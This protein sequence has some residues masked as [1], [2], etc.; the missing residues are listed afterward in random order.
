LS[1]VRLRGEDI[2]L[3]IGEVRVR[4]ALVSLKVPP[5]DVDEYQVKL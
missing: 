2:S 4:T 5:G 3:G 1:I